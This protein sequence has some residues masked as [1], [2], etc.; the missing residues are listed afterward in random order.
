MVASGMGITILPSTATQVKHYSKILCV[1]PF[2]TKIPKR[3]VALAWRVSFPRTK[4]I[5]ALIAALHA[6]KLS[7]ICPID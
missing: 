3:T 7:S 5:D 4:A 6:A 2:K 1:K